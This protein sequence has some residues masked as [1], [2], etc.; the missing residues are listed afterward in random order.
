MIG[1]QNVFLTGP[2]GSGKSYV[3]RQF[4]NQMEGRGKRVALTATTGIAANLLGGV[5][6]HSWAGIYY[7]DHSMS[8]NNYWTERLRN[9]EILI[10]DEISM[11]SANIFDKLNRLLVKA[12]HNSQPFGGVQVIVC[13]DFFQLPPVDRNNGGYAFESKSWKLLSLVVCSLSEQ[14]RQIN[15]KLFT[16]L[17]SLR[18]GLF[19][20]DNL[21]DL[22]TRCLEPK[23]DTPML[24]TH[25][26]AVEM[27]NRLKLDNLKGETRSYRQLVNGIPRAANELSAAVLTPKLLSL[28]TGAR[29]MFTANNPKVGYVNGTQGSVV[30]FKHGL[31]VVET[32]NR[33]RLTVDV[34][35]WTYL[36]YGQVLAELIQ[37]PLKLA[38]AIT[39]HKSQGMSL[40][41]AAIDL[42]RSFTYGM[43][44]VALSRIR[45]LDGLYLLGLNS[46]SLQ[47]DPKVRSFYDRCGLN[48]ARKQPADK[49]DI[50]IQKTALALY[51]SAVPDSF[52]ITSLGITKEQLELYKLELQ[53]CSLSATKSQ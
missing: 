32:D 14:H 29:V 31:P 12:R 38:W 47:T 41:T 42:T 35:R 1:G 19:S 50:S 8:A 46:R 28:K 23:S 24:L 52:I 5:T 25:N 53:N 27:N 10:I 9:A 30:G 36:E 6:I 4:V 51:S 26:Q 2:P 15:D 49:T 40:E 17:S 21:N 13:G 18:D 20:V 7:R 16:A 37:I 11:L 45:S 33:A 48:K 22:M 3:I 39:I 43:G 34:Y 44:Y